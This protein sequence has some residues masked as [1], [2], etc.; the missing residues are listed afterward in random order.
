M[1]KLLMMLGALIFG[2]GLFTEIKGKKVV[3]PAE[4][5]KE[6][7]ILDPTAE[8]KKETPA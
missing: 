4:P 7:P 6:T 8:P 3:A 2:A 1:G 5:K